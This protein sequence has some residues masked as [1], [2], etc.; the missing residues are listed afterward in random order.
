[1][2]EFGLLVVKVEMMGIYSCCNVNGVVSGKFF[3]Y[4]YVNVVDVV[5]FVLKDGWW[6]SVLNGWNGDECEVW[7]LCSV[8]VLVC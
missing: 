5:V 1:M 2:G 7:F 4:V 6:I 3:E 8:C